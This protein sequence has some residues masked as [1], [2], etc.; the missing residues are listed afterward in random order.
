MGPHHS[1]F[2][3]QF[4]R[5]HG[6]GTPISQ[7]HGDTTATVAMAVTPAVHPAVP[8]RGTQCIVLYPELNVGSFKLSLASKKDLKQN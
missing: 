4:P 2:L 1:G 3:T 6:P 8:C 7:H 5:A